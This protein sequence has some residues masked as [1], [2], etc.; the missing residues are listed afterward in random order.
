[1]NRQKITF[2]RIIE[3]KL[4]FNIMIEVCRRPGPRPR[5]A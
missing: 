2:C 5:P 3:F 1:L 4:A